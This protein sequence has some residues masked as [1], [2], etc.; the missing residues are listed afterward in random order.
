MTC[1][2]KSLI[3]NSDMARRPKDPTKPSQM[4]LFRP[5]PIDREL[6]DF[7]RKKT[8]MTISCVI[9]EALA[10]RAESMGL[11]IARLMEEHERYD[12]E[13]TT[14]ARSTPA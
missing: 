12:D 2:Y 6:I 7:L 9:R 14:D 5:R 3:N 1:I 13:R 8:T 11:N 4:I 10:Y